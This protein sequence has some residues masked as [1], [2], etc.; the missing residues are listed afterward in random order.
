MNV[1]HLCK[2]NSLEFFLA[3]VKFASSF[4]MIMLLIL[5]FWVILDSNKVNF[6]INIK[7]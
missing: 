7:N 6:P 3:R 1:N 5:L 2:N 4:D